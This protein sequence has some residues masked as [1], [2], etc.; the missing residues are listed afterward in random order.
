MHVAITSVV[1]D[2]L[3]IELERVGMLRLG[4]VSTR[5][6]ALVAAT[7][8]VAADQAYPEVLGGLA[9]AAAVLLE[10]DRNLRVAAHG[11]RGIGL[12]LCQA[13]RVELVHA[14]RDH[15][16][17]LGAI[18]ALEAHGTRR[19]LLEIVRREQHGIGRPDKLDVGHEHEMAHLGLEAV[20]GLAVDLDEELVGELLLREADDDHVLARRLAA[21]DAHVLHLLLEPRHP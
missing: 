9:H 14:D 1:P 21:D 2:A 6:A 5:V 13:T 10:R 7:A 18:E 3:C 15:D 17:A 16:A 20:E 4:K 8:N 11:A 19:Q 12:P